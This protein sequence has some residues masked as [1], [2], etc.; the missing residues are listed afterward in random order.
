MQKR[1]QKIGVYAGTFDPIHKGH[2]AFALAAAKACRL[3]NIV[4][5]P[6]A[7]PRGK[8]NVTPVIAR[9]G[10]IGAAIAAIPKLE[11]ATLDAERFTYTNTKSELEAL[12][13]NAHFTLLVGSDVARTLPQWQNLAQLFRQFPK[14]AIG[15]RKNDTADEMMLVMTPLQNEFNFEV[16]FCE[17][18]YAHAS[19]SALGLINHDE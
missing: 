16:C 6:E 11:V 14:V 19:S 1:S 15:L 2:I 9:V 7:K 18:A 4:F 8:V 17:T 3:D 12:Y 13:P 10:Q 5:I